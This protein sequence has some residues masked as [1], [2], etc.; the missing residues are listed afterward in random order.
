MIVAGKMLPVLAYGFVIGDMLKRMS[1]GED[2]DVQAETETLLFGATLEE[3]A[4]T[5]LETY[6]RA[7]IVYEGVIKPVGKAVLRHET[8]G[9]L[10]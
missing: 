9:I 7:N 2:V 10:G 4:Q 8:G 1:S 6:M 3:H 5:G